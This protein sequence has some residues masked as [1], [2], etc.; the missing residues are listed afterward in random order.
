MTGLAKAECRDIQQ[1]GTEESAAY[2]SQSN[3]LTEVGVRLVRGMFRTIKLC[4][5]ERI[6]KTIPAD[7]PLTAWMIEHATTILNA[8]TRRRRRH[9]MAPGTRQAVQ[10]ADGGV[11]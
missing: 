10:A 3:G 11:W 5:E 4:L 7:H 1:I 6:D 9:A 8:M 2:D